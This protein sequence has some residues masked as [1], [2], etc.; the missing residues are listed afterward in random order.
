MSRSDAVPFAHAGI[1]MEAAAGGKA[2]DVETI[3]PAEHRG[4][5]TGESQR[6]LF[7][8]A[9]NQETSSRA[10]AIRDYF[11]W[12]PAFLPSSFRTWEAVRNSAG[13]IGVSEI[14]VRWDVRI[15]KIFGFFLTARRERGW[16]KS[17]AC[18]RSGMLLKRIKMA[19][20]P[21][22][23]MR[24]FPVFVIWKS[25]GVLGL[26]KSKFGRLME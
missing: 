22:E 26:S 18:G 16:D 23:N 15:K 24:S 2:Q 25:F 20:F 17:Q 5:V 1:V 3:S 19:T 13:S 11:S 7:R 4:R 10:Q 12:L 14:D 9:G 6:E 21:R 8:N